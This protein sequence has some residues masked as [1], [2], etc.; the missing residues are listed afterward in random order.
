MLSGSITTATAQREIKKSS[1]IVMLNQQTFFLHITKRRQSIEQIARA[2]NVTPQ[3]ILASNPK[4]NGV[5]RNGETLLIPSQTQKTNVPQTTQTTTTQHQNP[6]QFI[7]NPEQHQQS[8]LK[9]QKIEDSLQ[10]E[11]A[12]QYGLMIRRGDVTAIDS[13]IN[14][15]LTDTSETLYYP[16]Q[17]FGETK[18]INPNLPLEIAVLLPFDNSPKAASRFVGFLN[19]MVLSIQELQ[20]E[21]KNINIRTIATNRTPQ[22]IRDIILSGQ[23]DG[24]DMIIGPVY[25]AE[26]EIAALYSAL[27]RV[28]IVS[29]L[30]SVGRANHPFVIEI[31]PNE[32]SYWEKLSKKLQTPNTNIVVVNHQHHSDSAAISQL[33]E[34]LPQGYKQL[35]YVDKHTEVDSLESSLVRRVENI[36]VLPVIN[37]PAV[38]EVL[39][40]FNSINMSGRYNIS[41]IG[42][43]SWGRFSRIDMELFFRMNVHMPSTYFFD[44]LQE[45]MTSFY[46]NYISSY[47]SLPSL[48]AMRGYD[49]GLLCVGLLLEYGDDVM[50]EL[51]RDTPTPLQT[52]YLF[53]QFSED[54]KLQNIDWPIA[55]YNRDYTIT[56]Q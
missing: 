54:S 6:E 1:Q 10:L 9:Q 46:Q 13:L 32:N 21:N 52:P 22:R 31:A 56:L 4:F 51:I 2:Y 11:T 49:V 36:I 5:I 37:E 41:V 27:N 26:F 43:P 18:P 15:Y 33:A 39:S 30:G 55:V 45:P 14:Y 50:F 42:L 7:E 8:Q 34:I 23:L 20:L 28:P 25:P 53:D 24:V 35:D 16:T 44:R 40:R 29:P 12:K 19:G 38:E 47:G 3:D 48:Y 17:K